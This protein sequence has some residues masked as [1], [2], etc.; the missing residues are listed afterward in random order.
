M[1]ELR[2][3]SFRQLLYRQEVASMSIEGALDIVRQRVL[4]SG[5]MEISCFVSGWLPTAFT[6]I[7]TKI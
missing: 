7:S 3:Q 6:M 2:P 1:R 5:L 4:Y